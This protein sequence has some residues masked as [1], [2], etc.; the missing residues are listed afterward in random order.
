MMAEDD[1]LGGDAARLSVPSTVMR[2]ALGLRCHR[3]CVAMTCVTSDE[4]MPK[5]SAPSAP[6]VEV[7]ESPQTRVRPGWRHALLGPDDM[8][9]A[10]PLVAEVEQGDAALR[11]VRRDV[12]RPGGGDADRDIRLRRGCSLSTIVVGRREAAI[13][14]A[15]ASCRARVRRAK[16]A[17][18]PSCIR[19]RST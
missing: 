15:Q 3:H 8:D 6:C 2:I 16:P 12:A 4:P 7:C 9:D 17:A 14:A 5:A 11:R 10:L 13:G 18:E 1:V 19:W